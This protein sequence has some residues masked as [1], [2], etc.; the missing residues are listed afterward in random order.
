MMTAVRFLR[1]WTCYNAGEIAG[2]TDEVILKLMEQGVVELLPAP[3][4]TAT[5]VPE[6]DVDNIPDPEPVPEPKAIVQPPKPK[7]PAGKKR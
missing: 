7:L 3:S 1:S 2:F 5:S 6:P 4:S